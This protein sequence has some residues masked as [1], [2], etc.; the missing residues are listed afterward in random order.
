M[1]RHPNGKRGIGVADSIT[2]KTDGVWKA[3]ELS[4]FVASVDTIYKAALAVRITR[5]SIPS[6]EEQIE[7]YLERWYRY[8][9]RYRIPREPFPEDFM[10]PFPPS[11]D[12]FSEFSAQRSSYL[13]FVYENII[14]IAPDDQLIVGKV[15]MGS[16]G[17]ISFEGIGEV[18]QQVRD[19]IKDARWREEHERERSEIEIQQSREQ[20][21]Q[22]RE[23]HKLDVLKR[24][25]EMQSEYGEIMAGPT[26][27]IAADVLKELGQVERLEIE[28]K[29]QDVET[30]TEETEG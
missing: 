6:V 3:N 4:R 24:L 30:D 12:A 29:V 7:T 1:A 5:R 21:Q 8:F 19:T 15:R 26:K 27:E 25:L 18:I 22:N 14:D 17:N 28:G 2:F 23:I 11:P 9:R 20:M 16:P 10:F 13:A